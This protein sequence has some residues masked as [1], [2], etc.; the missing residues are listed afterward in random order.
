LASRGRI[1]AAIDRGKHVFVQVSAHADNEGNV[2]LCGSDRR[3][4]ELTRVDLLADTIVAACRGVV[5]A[6]RPDYVVLNWCYS[7]CIVDTVLRDVRGVVA[8]DGDVESDVVVSTMRV[9]HETV[10]RRSV[11]R[12]S[13]INDDVFEYAAV[14]AQR[15]ATNQGR[16]LVLPMT[17]R[18]AKLSW[19]ARKRSHTNGSRSTTRNAKTSSPR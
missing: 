10:A 14:E 15:E 16:S 2:H 12:V 3:G 7:N 9:F 19:T 11:N 17:P 5:P 8:W 6:Q 1:G 13:A 4:L 18:A